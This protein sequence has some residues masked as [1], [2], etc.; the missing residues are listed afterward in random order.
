MKFYEIEQRSD[1]W[2]AA[3]LGK[4]TASQFGRIITAGGKP[5]GQQPLYMSEL[6]GERIFQRPLGKDVSGIAAVK[7][8]IETEAEAAEV[9]S[10]ILGVDL[11]PGGFMVEDG[12]RYGCSPDRLITTGNRRELVEIKCPEIPRHICNLLFGPGDDYRA[13][14]QGQLLISGFDAVNFFSYRS[15]CPPRHVRIQRDDPYIRA[16][17]TILD[18]FCEE[19]EANHQRALAA[20]AWGT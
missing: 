20:G 7:Y 14:V 3:R 8:G 1:E 4:P 6:V 12:G 11:Q 18:Q 13:Q 15:D 17:D 10:D 19:L 16:L 9:L 5:S 2:Y